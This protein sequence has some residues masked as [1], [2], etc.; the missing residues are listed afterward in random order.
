[1]SAPATPS[2]RSPLLP[3]LLG[4]N[5]LLLIGLLAVV[6]LRGGPAP[7]AT[8]AEA[9]EVQAPAEGAG[10]TVKLADFVVRLRNPEVDRFARLSFELELANEASRG[11][12]TER[13]P[14]VRD[15]IIAYLSDRTLEEL[16]GSEGLARA[17]SELLVRLAEVLPPGDV[18]ALWVTDF[19]VQ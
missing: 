13:M 19:V 9:A 11:R 4:L 10:P 5:S 14:R 15:A 17:K 16:R 2:S 8:S 7:A 3:V 1:M 6:L 12:L 18:R